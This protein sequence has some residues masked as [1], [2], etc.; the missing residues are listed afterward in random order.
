MEHSGK[1]ELPR[2]Y[3]ARA[4]AVDPRQER[5]KMPSR[6]NEQSKQR[7]AIKGSSEERTFRGRAA[8]PETRVAHGMSCGTH[9][10]TWHRNRL[11]SHICRDPLL[12]YPRM[13]I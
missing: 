4:N 3:W 9:P 12:L 13:D 1:D 5:R 7:Q 10:E 2:Y 8:K 11:F 6:W